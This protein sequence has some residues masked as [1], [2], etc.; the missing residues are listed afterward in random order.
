MRGH[1]DPRSG[2]IARRSGSLGSLS[3]WE[4]RS[5]AVDSSLWGRLVLTVTFP[6]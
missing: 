6:L 5:G 3:L 1:P 4:W 2:I